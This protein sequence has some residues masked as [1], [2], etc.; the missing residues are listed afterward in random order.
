MAAEAGQIPTLVR[1]FVSRLFEGQTAENSIARTQFA[2]WS[3]ALLSLPT[4]QVG[5][6]AFGKYAWFARRYPELV[7][8]ATWSDKL[9]YLGFSVLAIGLLA[10]VVW[11]GMFPDR[12]DAIVFSALPVRTRTLVFSRLTAMMGVA[13]LFVVGFNVPAV[14][15]YAAATGQYYGA[16]GFARHVVAHTVA[17]SAAAMTVFAL[18][19]LV[20]T[21]VLSAV[22]TRAAARLT[23]LVQALLVVFVVQ[24]VM[25]FPSAVTR[26]PMATPDL[27]SFNLWSPPLWYLGLYEWV[28]G[29]SRQGWRAFAIRGAGVSAGVVITAL[30]A[31]V[32]SYQ[33]ITRRALEAADLGGPRRARLWASSTPRSAVRGFVLIT[34]ARS[35]HHRLL[36]A[37][38]IGFGL[39]LVL[40][41]IIRAASSAEPGLPPVRAL[42]MPLILIF[43]AATGMRMLYGIPHEVQAN[44]VFRLTESRRRDLYLAGATD[45]A[46]LVAVVAVTLLVTPLLWHGWGARAAAAH[47]A[48]CTVAG[49][50]LAE[51]L[52]VGLRKIPF[53]CVHVPG[54]ANV[55]MWWPAYLIAFTNFSFTFAAL[56]QAL[57]TNAALA[58]GVFGFGVA[59]WA[60]LRAWRTH[61]ART[62]EQF[63]YDEEPEGVR[64]VVS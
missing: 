47:A 50:L 44:W 14:A 31:Y 12:R 64:S 5:T 55:R 60:S 27:A 39:A 10:L 30:I 49:A 58:A 28:G 15:I 54:S 57:M 36:L 16:L 9:F 13:L 19:V 32:L 1:A 25:L 24:G 62:L 56:A 11:D 46:L 17:T 7:D 4:F 20:Q 8:A 3:I 41:E 6:R 43:L 26:L 21:V 23:L 59:L 37:I 34:L 40:P 52:T 22:G 61:A 63:V 53:T 18:V 29:T 48:F 35:R 42:A 51:G 38:F 45:A 2:I 33:R